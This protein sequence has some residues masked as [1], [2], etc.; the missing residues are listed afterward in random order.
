M[1]SKLL[2][3][4]IFAL[5]TGAHAGQADICFGPARLLTDQG[6][7]TTNT[8]PFNCPLAGNNKTINQL[9]LDGWKIVQM[10]DITISSTQA[11]AQLIIERP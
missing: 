3:L 2:C 10:F 7:P 1:R 9:A 11:S 6:N 8:T 4:A 5:T